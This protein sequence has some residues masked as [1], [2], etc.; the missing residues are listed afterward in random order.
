MSDGFRVK[1]PAAT[2]AASDVMLPRVA[3]QRSD[4]R[5][6]SR[7][8]AAEMS[9]PR[10]VLLLGTML[11]GVLGGAALLLAVVIEVPTTAR[12]D[13]VTENE[14]I[15]RRFYATVNDAVRT[16]DLSLLDQVAVRTTDQI[17][18]S[19]ETGCDVHCRVSALHRL[20]PDVR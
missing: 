16:G 18:D 20:A 3:S 7:V 2:L 1:M 10:V 4:P 15:A 9:R 13:S 11:L 14:A 19:A 12:A 8:P 17:P 5:S 6:V